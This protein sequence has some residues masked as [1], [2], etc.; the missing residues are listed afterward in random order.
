MPRALS[1]AALAGL[2]SANQGWFETAVNSGTGES[3]D[4]LARYASAFSLAP[5]RAGLTVAIGAPNDVARKWREIYDN[6]Y[7]FD[8]ANYSQV[9]PGRVSLWDALAPG[10][11]KLGP[12]LVGNKT[13]DSFGFAVA[14]A[15][16]PA[17]DDARVVYRVAAAAAELDLES[18][19]ATDDRCFIDTPRTGVVRVYD[20]V[21][22]ADAVPVSG[23]EWTQVGSNINLRGFPNVFDEAIG[24]KDAER[25]DVI[26]AMASEGAM[27]GR[28]LV[29]G[30]PSFNREVSY[31]DPAGRAFVYDLVEGDWALTAT[32]TPEPRG[33]T[34]YWGF[35][36]TVAM[37]DDGTT[38]AVAAPSADG[39][40]G[41]FANGYASVWQLAAGAGAWSKVAVLE[42]YRGNDVSP[43]AFCGQALSFS[44]GGQRLAL[45]CP[46]WSYDTVDTP[47]RKDYPAAVHVYE[48]DAGEWV[49]VGREIVSTDTFGET[50]TSF[51]VSVSLDANGTR[52]LVGASP[53]DSIPV[54]G[55]AFA[56]YDQDASGNWTQVGP[57]VEESGDAGWDLLG[58]RVALTGDGETVLAAAPGLAAWWVSWDLERPNRRVNPG[59][60]RF[61][62][63]G[64]LSDAASTTRAFFAVAAALAA[65]ALL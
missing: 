34:S 28:R 43:L 65:A 20:I 61:Y 39:K 14:A 6:S 5:G 23:A 3:S 1:I 53:F 49:Q 46:G 29:I 56:V 25:P 7:P 41:G 54:F 47:N 8:P 45:S 9:P 36:S 17:P 22:S 44:S 35:A 32:L 10:N 13:A 12:D 51:G 48:E 60:L 63:W 64:D 40:G 30:A 19:N 58:Y 18:C 62:Q 27:A 57:A 38:V 55:T 31:T 42:P 11:V 50:R 4:V 21:L 16:V 52:V 26:L 37:S 15:R 2:V 24:G 33:A 59:E